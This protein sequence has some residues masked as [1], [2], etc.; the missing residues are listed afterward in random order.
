MR[1]LKWPAIIVYIFVMIIALI[2]GIAWSGLFALQKD[3]ICVPYE[4]SSYYG[5]VNYHI[6]PPSYTCS[7]PGDEED[8]ISGAKNVGY[9]DF[10]QKE[11]DK[12]KRRHHLIGPDLIMLSAFGF[13]ALAFMREE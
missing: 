11:L 7:W 9:L 2:L 4:G 13:V 8:V 3:H 1:Y 12:A 5:Q 10:D 6:L